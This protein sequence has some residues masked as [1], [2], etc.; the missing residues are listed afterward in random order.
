MSR[1]IKFKFII[2]DKVLS[3]PYTIEE[4]LNKSEDDIIDDMEVCSC[5][6][7]ESTNHCEC[8]SDYPDSKITGKIQSTGLVDKTGKEIFEGDIIMHPRHDRPHSQK[9]KIKQVKC[10]VEWSSGKPSGNKED[11]PIMITNPSVFQ[12]RPS[13]FPIPIDDYKSKESRWGF[14]WS[15]FHD[16]EIIGNVFENTELLNK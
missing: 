9:R 4:L 11:N 3:A 12:S 7:N 15:E 1:E 13:F 8:G 2:D 10:I 5:Q 16:C 6:L 14:N